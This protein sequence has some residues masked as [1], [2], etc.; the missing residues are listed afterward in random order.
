MSGPP[1]EILQELRV[2]VRIEVLRIWRAADCCLRC[3]AR[4]QSGEQNCFMVSV[5]L[6]G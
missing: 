1:V 3:S 2:V 6:F 4:T 5:A